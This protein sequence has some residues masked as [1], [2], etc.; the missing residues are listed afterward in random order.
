MAKVVAIGQPVNDSEREAIAYLRDHLPD[1]FTVIHNF[2]LRQGR[3][4][5]EIDIALLGPHCVHVIDVK[6]TRGHVDV[7]G[8][9]WYP[10]RRAPYHSPLAILR[11]HAKALK[12]LICDQHPTVRA[13]RSVHV[14]AAVLMT[15][16]DAH[17]QDPRRSGRAFG[18]L[19]REVHRVFQVHEAHSG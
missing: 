15:A 5:F 18:R 13:L 8:S 16:S 3:S 6:G 14:D 2:E 11:G 1:G 19:S 4:I 10:E 9:K 7:H 12:S 17:V